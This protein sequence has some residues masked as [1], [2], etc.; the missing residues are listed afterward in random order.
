VSVGCDGRILIWQL[1]QHQKTLRL[2]DGYLPSYLFM[3]FTSYIIV[4][5]IITFTSAWQR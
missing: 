1:S 5:V 2:A 4:F 3:L